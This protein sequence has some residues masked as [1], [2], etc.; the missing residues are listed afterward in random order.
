MNWGSNILLSNAY[1][2]PNSN[3]TVLVYWYVVV[4]GLGLVLS[5]GAYLT[6][7]YTVTNLIASLLKKN[8]L[9]LTLT[10]LN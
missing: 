1:Y 4:S 6:Q 9:W 5:L 8:K 3:D 7:V 2:I 10:L